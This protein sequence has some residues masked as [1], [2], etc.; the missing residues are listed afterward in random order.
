MAKGGGRRASDCKV[1]ETLETSQNSC[2]SP[3]GTMVTA[4]RYTIMEWFLCTLAD[5]GGWE[6][7][8]DL[9]KYKFWN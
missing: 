6:T 7:D 2:A 3:G 4:K 9:V 8:Q 1:L 5:N